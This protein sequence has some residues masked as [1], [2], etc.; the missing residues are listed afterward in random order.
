MHLPRAGIIPVIWV[1][2]V[3]YYGLGTDSQHHT[4]IDLGGR[5]ED[6]DRHHYDNAAREFTEESLGVFGQ[7]RG[8]D[9]YEMPFIYNQDCALFFVPWIINEQLHE[10]FAHK[11]SQTPNPEIIAL[12]WLT[13]NQLLSLTPQQMYWKP[14]RLIQENADLIEAIDEKYQ[15]IF[16][17]HR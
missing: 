1:S 15:E 11:V 14:Q 17:S 9:L 16:L 6:Y 5:R 13:L 7:I 3:N 10:N 8:E 2:G 12:N 4:Y